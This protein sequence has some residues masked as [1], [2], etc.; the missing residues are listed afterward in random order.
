MVCSVR[1][2]GT[3]CAVKVENSSV[4]DRLLASQELCSVEVFTATNY[5]STWTKHLIKEG[6]EIF[7]MV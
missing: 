4:S 5:F 6:N 1:G 2:N 7:H 3:S